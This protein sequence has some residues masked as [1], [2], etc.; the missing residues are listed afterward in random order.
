MDI[1]SSLLFQHVRQIAYL[2]ALAGIVSF[3]LALLASVVDPSIG[4]SLPMP[5]PEL[6]GPFRWGPASQ[7]TA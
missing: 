2:L 1:A 4:R 3:V 6:M 5:E 7:Q